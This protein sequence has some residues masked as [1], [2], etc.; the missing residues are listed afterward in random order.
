VR[1]LEDFDDDQ[2]AAMIDSLERGR[3][4]VEGEIAKLEQRLGRGGPA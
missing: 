2:V 4:L 3:Q 1:I